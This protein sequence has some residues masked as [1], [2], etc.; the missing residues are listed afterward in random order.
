MSYGSDNGKH[1][2]LGIFVV[3]SDTSNKH[4]LLCG[5]S[6]AMTPDDGTGNYDGYVQKISVMGIT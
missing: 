3:E 2:N 5:R 1:I 4:I 6:N